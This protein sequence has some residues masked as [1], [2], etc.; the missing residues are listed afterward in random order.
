M[1]G[2]LTLLSIQPVTENMG[3]VT[4]ES[5]RPVQT[6]CNLRN[7]PSFNSFSNAGKH[8][9]GRD[10]TGAGAPPPKSPQTGKTTDR[11]SGKYESLLIERRSGIG[12]WR[13]SCCPGKRER[14]ERYLERQRI[15]KGRR[16]LKAARDLRLVSASSLCTGRGQTG[17][18]KRVDRWWFGRPQTPR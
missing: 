3:G 1:A 2:V 10:K 8:F 18:R 14:P 5:I 7:L 11:F 13:W 9:A 6:A 12:A 16:E 15:L 17:K 4:R